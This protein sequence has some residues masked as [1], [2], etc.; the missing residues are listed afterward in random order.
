M[1]PIS[2]SL[3][4]RRLYFR[5]RRKK[6]VILLGKD[7]ERYGYYGLWEILLILLLR[8]NAPIFLKKRRKFPAGPCSVNEEDGSAHLK[9]NI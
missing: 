8:K 2:R 7:F 1:S 4:R 5:V 6:T 9:M 3:R